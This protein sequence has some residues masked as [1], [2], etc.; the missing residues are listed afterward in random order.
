MTFRRSAPAAIIAAV[1]V[2]IA[3]VTFASNRLF[4][5]L[6]SAVE[7]GQFRLMQSMV[8]TALRNA[9]DDALARAEVI[10]ALPTTRAAV[11]AK[12]RDRLLAE[13]AAMFTGQKE[14]RGVDQAQFHVLP[15]TSLLRL[16]DHLPLDPQHFGPVSEHLSFNTARRS[17]RNCSCSG[18]LPAKTVASESM[19]AKLSRASI[20]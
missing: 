4:T 12:E 14:R 15:A 19:G 2:V 3:A 17:W 10:A 6:T 7:D 20:V 11:A 18:S 1:V 8:E 13:Y 16:Q 9:A 5:G